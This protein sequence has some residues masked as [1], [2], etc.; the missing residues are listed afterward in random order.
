MRRFR[1]R[2]WIVPPALLQ[3]AL[4]LVTLAAP[5]RPRDPDVAPARDRRVHPRLDLQRPLLRSVLVVVVCPRP[6]VRA[7]HLAERLHRL[8]HPLG[9]PL[10]H[11][12]PGLDGQRA[13]RR[14]AHGQRDAH[15]HRRRRHRLPGRIVLD[16]P[17]L[18]FESPPLGLGRRI[19]HRRVIPA[20]PACRHH[21]VARI[22][23]VDRVVCAV[24]LLV[25]RR[26]LPGVPGGAVRRLIPHLLI[27]VVAAVL[28]RLFGMLVHRALPRSGDAAASGA[29]AAHLHLSLSYTTRASP[30]H[31]PRLTAAATGYWKWTS[32]SRTL[33]VDWAMHEFGGGG[34][35]ADRQRPRAGAA[36]AQHPGD[37]PR[38]PAPGAAGAGGLRVLQA[39]AGVRLRI[40]V[41]QGGGGNARIR[42]SG[43]PGRT[44]A[45]GVSGPA[46]PRQ[47][48]R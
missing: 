41:F 34:P 32:S 33:P 30:A 5:V 15:A 16:R 37:R 18:R 47:R 10:D 43:A 24:C 42:V 31:H 14:F 19:A 26:A 44:C 13:D 45:P 2:S 48:S 3:P 1:C 29:A 7:S 38:A 17:V 6:R 12:R 21:L 36:G 9:C 40:G 35:G 8:A 11:H 28:G 39:A 22:A 23:A 25:S 46:R 27:P 20:L 4:L